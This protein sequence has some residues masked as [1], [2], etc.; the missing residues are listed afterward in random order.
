MNK[1]NSCWLCVSQEKTKDRNAAENAW[2]I[3]V[4]HLGDKHIRCQEN[5]GYVC[6]CINMGI[7]SIPQESSI[8]AGWRRSHLTFEIHESVHRDIITK[9]NQRDATI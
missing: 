5:E 1:H 7:S 2:P 6:H 3:S 9:N 8:N 4:G